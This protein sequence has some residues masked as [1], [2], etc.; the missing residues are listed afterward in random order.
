MSEESTENITKSDNQTTIVHQFFL[1]IIYYILY[2]FYTL[3]PQ[4][5]NLNTGFTLY[6]CL[7][8]SVKLTKNADPDKYKCSG[9]GVGFDS[10]SQFSFADESMGRNVIIFRAGMNSSVNVGNKNKDILILCKG[11]TQGLDIQL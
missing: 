3:G 6:N 2:I 1:I 9:Y 5:R 4:L 7:F 8:G 11:S 10:L